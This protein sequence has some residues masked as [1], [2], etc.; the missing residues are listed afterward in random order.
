MGWV[1]AG[2]GPKFGSGTGDG[3]QLAEVLVDYLDGLIRIEIARHNHGHIVGN[4]KLIK[5]VF[6]VDE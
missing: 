4:I 1:I 5:K 3:L 6:Y 2:W